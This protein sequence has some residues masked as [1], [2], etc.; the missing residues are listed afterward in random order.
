MPESSSEKAKA[1]QAQRLMY[2]VT[3]L[4]IVPLLLALWIRH[5]VH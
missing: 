3:A 1:R 4:M 2:I 5:L